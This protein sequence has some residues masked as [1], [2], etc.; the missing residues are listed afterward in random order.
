MGATFL[1]K[2]IDNFS[3]QRLLRAA[4]GRVLRALGL[5]RKFPNPGDGETADN[6]RRSKRRFM[7]RKKSS[8]INLRT[9]FTK[10]WRYC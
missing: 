5:W 10:G 3:L 1:G 7:L 9:G 6:R 4:L 2:C 8:D